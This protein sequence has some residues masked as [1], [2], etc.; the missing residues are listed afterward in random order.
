M[1]KKIFLIFLLLLLGLAGGTLWFFFFHQPDPIVIDEIQGESSETESDGGESR[2]NEGVLNKNIHIYTGEDAQTVNESITSV[3]FGNNGLILRFS[4]DTESGPAVLGRGDIFWL[5]GSESTPLKETYI[6]KV[7]SN[8]LQ[9]EERVV[10]VE[11]PMIDEVF[12]E[13]YLDGE[14]AISA[15]NIKTISTVDGVTVTPVEAVPAD[16]LEA[17]FEENAGTENTAMYTELAY[18]QDTAALSADLGNF[19]LEIDADLTELLNI[20]DSGK[21]V[22]SKKSETKKSQDDIARVK[23]SCKVTG[24]IG[25]EDLKVSFTA[26]YDKEEYGM[27]ELS[28]GVSG[29]Q[30]F[31][32]GLDMSISG[33]VS[34][35]TTEADVLGFV[36]LQ[37]LKKKVFPIAYF[38]CT[39]SVPVSI[40]GIGNTLNKNIENKNKYMPFSCGFMVYIDIYGNLSLDMKMNYSYADAFENN[41]VLVR[42]NK[43]VGSFE[44]SADE[45]EIAYYTGIKASAD[46][47]V[48]IGTSAL[49]YL[50]NINIVDVGIVKA[51]GEI[52]GTGS[53]EASSD[54]EKNSGLNVSFYAR[55]Y[56]KIL[57]VKAAIKAQANLWRL[58]LS[59]GFDWE[60]TMLDLTILETGQK[61]DT[62]FD[63]NSMTWHKMTAED[64]NSFYYKG[65]NGNLLR[66]SKNLLS[67]TT[68]YEGDFFSICGLDQSYIYVLEPAGDESYDVRRIGKDGTV[69]KIILEDVKYVLRMGEDVFYYV[70][71][72]SDNQIYTLD[73]YSLEKKKFAQFE[74]NVELMSEEEGGFLVTVQEDNAFSWLLGPECKYYLLSEDGQTLEVYEDDLTPQQ[75]VKEDNGIYYAAFEIVSNGYLRETAIKGYWLSENGQTSVEAE[76][77]SGWHPTESGIFTELERE[78]GAYDVV[79]YQASDGSS[80]KITE[81][82]SASAFF[83]FVQDDTGDWY[84]MDQTETELV[85]YRMDAS[86]TEKEKIDAISLEEIPCD[87]ESCTMELV[88]NRIFFYT[89]PSWS[90]SEVLYRY[91]LY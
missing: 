22:Q 25:L 21:T 91:N 61:R 54:E 34:G 16:F 23:D 18:M 46:A 30:V 49:L 70:P 31:S 78:D 2:E 5:D 15:D 69:T 80:R 42:D 10:T 83:T 12:D 40:S 50:F 48:H 33:E 8:T 11:S 82:D 17:A 24:R 71:A 19:V 73:R 53:L 41:L 20:V 58:S 7:L 77:I 60:E 88:N 28:A 43:I 66:E 90:D 4:G 45:P 26:D 1:R 32:T 47:D 35:K 57:D 56:A 38:D 39:S 86:F 81:T 64:E 14:F 29:R 65:T 72:F 67:R 59:E 36:K 62:H 74:D 3:E 55:L 75:C 37:G 9:G 27:K 68:L 79:L 51:G 76:G 84:Y 13:L 6:G 85:L 87:M 44:S 52:L 63:E 89:M